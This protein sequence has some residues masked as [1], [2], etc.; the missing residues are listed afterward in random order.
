MTN[1]LLLVSATSSIFIV[2][3][4]A[5]IIFVTVQWVVLRAFLRILRSLGFSESREKL[6]VGIAVG[7]F[8]LINLPLLWFIIETVVSP[9][10]L[11]LYAPPPGYEKVVRPF[12]YL[13][14]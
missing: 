12:A 8:A 7:L 6:A 14:F 4:I 2:R 11:L 1:L 10:A 5:S 13:F 9:R 3:V